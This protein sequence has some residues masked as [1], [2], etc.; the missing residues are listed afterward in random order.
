[1]S[2]DE[3]LYFRTCY[4]FRASKRLTMKTIVYLM[5]CKIPK[6]R[7]WYYIQ[8]WVK[9]RI[10]SLKTLSFLEE[11]FTDEYKNAIKSWPFSVL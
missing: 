6:I 11:N 1:M 2:K 7:Q 3:L 5:R 9:L 8:K 10:F 4:V